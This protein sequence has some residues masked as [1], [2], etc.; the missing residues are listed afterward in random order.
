MPTMG[1]ELTPRQKEA[2]TMRFNGGCSYREI[3]RY[4]KIDPMCA[5][6]LVQRAKRRAMVYGQRQGMTMPEKA[7]EA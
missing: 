2:I 4:M 6:R 1:L 7:G 5:W 3:G